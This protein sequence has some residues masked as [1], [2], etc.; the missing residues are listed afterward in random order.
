MRVIREAKKLYYHELIS[1]S[2]N[3][4]RSTWK[5]INKETVI[6]QTMVNIAE[7]QVGESKLNNPN[8]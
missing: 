3:K 6:K 7:I 1:H 4:I 5:I 8:E 2:E